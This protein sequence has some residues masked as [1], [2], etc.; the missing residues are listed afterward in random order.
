MGTT[1]HKFELLG[2]GRAPFKVTAYSFSPA[3]VRCDH[4]GRGL[5]HVW[6]VLSADRREFMVGSTCVR[7]VRDPAM[8][9]QM[10]LLRPADKKTA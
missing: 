3:R 10:K 7:K 2:L 1:L 6:H 9:A 5:K 8:Y 4:C